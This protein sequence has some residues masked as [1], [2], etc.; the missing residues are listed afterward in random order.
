MARLRTA[1]FTFGSSVA[2]ILVLVIT[3]GIRWS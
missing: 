3:Q 1:L 2:P